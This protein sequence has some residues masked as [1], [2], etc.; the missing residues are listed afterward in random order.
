MRA[1]RETLRYNILMTCYAIVDLEATDTSGSENHGRKIIQIGIVILE[2][3]KILRTFSSEVNPH[4]PLTENIMRLTGLKDEKLQ[5]APDFSELIPELKKILAGCV[6]VAHNVIFDWGLLARSFTEYGETLEMQRVDTVEL[7]KIFFPTFEKYGLDSLKTKLGLENKHLHTALSDARETA[8]LLVKIQSEIKKLPSLVIQE[9][10]E[11]ASALTYETK[12]IIDEL[13]PMAGERS[14][15]FNFYKYIATQKKLSGETSV[16][17][18][19]KNPI[20]ISEDFSE[21]LKSL[22]LKKRK[23]QNRIADY[24]KANLDETNPTFIEAP[25]GSGKTIAYLLPLVAVGRKVVVSTTTK[26]LQEQILQDLAPKLTDTFGLQTAK[27]MAASNYVSIEKVEKYL[28]EKN[29][30]TNTEIFKMKVLVWLTQTRTGELSELSKNVTKPEMFDSIS[31]LGYDKID[32]DFWKLANKQALK[33]DILVVN[34]AYLVELLRKKS[35]IFSSRTL[36]VDEAQGLL[37]V[38]ES[39]NQEHLEILN[40]LL[41]LQLLNSSDT[42]TDLEN[43]LFQLGKIPLNREKIFVEAAELG[44]DKISEFMIDPENIYW[45]TGN[46]LNSS[47]PDFYNFKK[48]L[49][50]KQKAIFISAS[51]AFSDKQVLLPELLGFAKDYKF[52]KIQSKIAK[53]QKLFAVADGLPVKN[54][55]VQD[56]SYY[57]LKKLTELAELNRPMI[58]LFSSRQ[59]LDWTARQFEKSSIKVGIQQAGHLANN[60]L[61]KK[62]F[63]D[64]KFQILLATGAFWEG[65]DFEKQKRAILVIPRLPF[66]TPEDVLTRK[67]SEKYKNPFYDFNLPMAAMKLRQAMGRLNRKKSQRSAVVVLDYRIAGNS[68]A[69]RLRKNLEELVEIETGN[70]DELLLQIKEFLE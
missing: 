61:L 46:T 43:L 24:I 8:E 20:K 66:A 45:T 39:A 18:E 50:E 54:S 49:F 23:I 70:F 59:M 62:Q 17:T 26:V 67:F 42:R 12:L 7:S 63:D 14:D 30:G 3:G 5:Q 6:F 22:G 28:S 52:Y 60:E 69:K 1:E 9:I 57:L 2:N 40:E 68:Y 34:H 36:I 35:E 16:M 11:H 31:N 47:R 15:E 41:P 48:L 65:V 4:E 10:C 13:A 56:Y 64:E 58:V 44:L 53:N 29:S 33:S 51:I 37:Q 55:T 19:N 32:T 27:L 21:N 25:T 38:L